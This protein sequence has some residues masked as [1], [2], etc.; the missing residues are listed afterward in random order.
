MPGYYT[1]P[2][3]NAGQNRGPDAQGTPGQVL[4]LLDPVARTTRWADGGSGSGEDGT[5]NPA[6]TNP[7]GIWYGDPDTPYSGNITVDETGAVISGIAV[8]FHSDANE[9]AII[10][11]YDI[12]SKTGTYTA[13]GLNL[14]YLTRTPSGITVNIAEGIAAFVPPVN[15]V[16]PALDTGVN[17]SIP[18]PGET[19]TT[20][21]GTWD[22]PPTSYTYKWFIDSVEQ[23][24]ETANALTLDPKWIGLSVYA[25]VTAIN[26]EG[27]ASADSNTLTIWHPKDERGIAD[28]DGLVALGFDGPQSAQD[29]PSVPDG[30]VQFWKLLN[31]ETQGA[32]VDQVYQDNTAP[33]GAKLRSGNTPAGFDSVHFNNADATLKGAGI[34]VTGTFGNKP[35]CYV[36]N[37]LQDPQDADPDHVVFGMSQAGQAAGLI[38][39]STKLGGSLHFRAGGRRLTSD[40]FVFSEGT[41]AAGWH[42]FGGVY[43]WAGDSLQCRVDGAN[44]GSEAN[45][46]SGGGNSQNSNTDSHIGAN[47]SGLI[48]SRG[49]TAAVIVSTPATLLT[50]AEVARIERYLGLLIGLDIPLQES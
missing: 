18:Y 37:A 29:V 1:F 39:M 8:V 32:Y 28:P 40:G 11:T 35:I 45:F 47:Q 2:V 49:Y 38:Q 4:E 7:L 3:G 31:R 43:N 30:D 27:S 50:A 23:V 36:W 9:P 26:S 14:I 24:G 5:G 33:F 25:E 22:G 17:I 19:I 13:G 44:V 41:F 46:T 34:T 6:L 48:V 20:D 10:T 12:E 16:P 21:N 42:L 15:T